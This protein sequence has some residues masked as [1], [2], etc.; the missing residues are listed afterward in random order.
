M[1]TDEQ[2]VG[3]I[4]SNRGKNFLSDGIISLLF[5]EYDLVMRFGKLLLMNWVQ[6]YLR[7]QNSFV[8][9]IDF[10][11]LELAFEIVLGLVRNG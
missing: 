9:A 11:G 4:F 8:S 5:T 6:S 10:I 1:I 2:N 7:E 3:M